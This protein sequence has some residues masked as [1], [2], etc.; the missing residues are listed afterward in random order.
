M[1]YPSLNGSGKEV[2]EW[3]KLMNKINSKK[4]IGKI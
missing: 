1:S 4:R 2:G 3:L